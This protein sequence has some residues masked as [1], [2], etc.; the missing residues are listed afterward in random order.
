[1]ENKSR[2]VVALPKIIDLL[3]GSCKNAFTPSYLEHVFDEYKDVWR[4]PLSMDLNR[5]IKGVSEAGSIPLH[6]FS[7]EGVP[8]KRVLHFEEASIYEISANIFPDSYLSHY[9]AVVA[10]GI[11]EQ[12]PKTVY[13][14]VEQ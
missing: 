12:I 2:I 10:W 13:I 5:F 7:F 9:S 8:D 4:L 1:M 14:K 6:T 3:I 11:T